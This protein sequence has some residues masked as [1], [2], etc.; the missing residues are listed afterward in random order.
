[1]LALKNH[2][3]A[4]FLLVVAREDPAKL[5]GIVSHGDLLDA[6]LHRSR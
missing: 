4:T 3:R 6:Q 2:P 1:M 5:V